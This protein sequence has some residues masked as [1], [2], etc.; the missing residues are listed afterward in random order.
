[1]DVARRG[2]NFGFRLLPPFVF[3]TRKPSSNPS[4]ASNA[5][6]LY[7]QLSP[8]STPTSDELEGW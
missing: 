1:M 3:D 4:R 8:M 5:Q 7:R 6:P 2:P